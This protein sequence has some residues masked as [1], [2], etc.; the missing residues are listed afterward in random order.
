MTAAVAGTVLRVRDLDVYYGAIAAVRDVNLEVRD[1]EIVCLLG[2]NGAGKSTVLNAIL[3]DV[4][5]RRGAIEFRRD[6]EWLALQNYPA[7]ARAR[8]GIVSISA[9]ENVLPRFTVQENLDVGAYLRTDKAAVRD[10]M[11]RQFA[12]F[13]MLK[14]RRKQ[15]AGTLS[16]G[17]QKILGIARAMMGRPRLLVLDEPSL[18]LSAAAMDAVFGAILR[19]NREDGIEI[20]I[21]E[22]NVKKAIEIAERAYV[23]RIGGVEFEARCETLSD[24]PRIET[25]YF[26][27]AVG[28]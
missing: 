21:V 20:L 2:P 12:R 16:G 6:G 1:G 28:A 9:Q 4:L 7:Y 18:G 11:D 3:G 5:T 23:M 15:F 27:G 24:D 17:Q 10:D 22:Q 26:G 13:P 25:A 14:E 19:L 8:F